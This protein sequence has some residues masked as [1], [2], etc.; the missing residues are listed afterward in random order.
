MYGAEPGGWRLLSVSRS[1]HQKAV[2][3]IP[4]AASGL[5]GAAV[6]TAAAELSG[7]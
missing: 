5:R 7:K 4:G 3:F 2:W 1:D 6:C